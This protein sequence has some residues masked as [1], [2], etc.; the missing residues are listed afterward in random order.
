M[1]HWFKHASEDIRKALQ[2]LKLQ[3][4]RYHRDEGFRC[5]RAASHRTPLCSSVNALNF[6]PSIDPSG[7]GLAFQTFLSI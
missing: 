7:N 5:G 3:G 1:R 6:F 2:Y 4:N